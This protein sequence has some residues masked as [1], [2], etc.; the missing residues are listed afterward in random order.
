MELEG[1]VNSIVITEAEDRWVWRPNMDD[2]F[3]VKSLYV[4]LD[5]LLS[6]CIPITLFEAFAYRSMW[7]TA[8]PSKV[9]AFAWQLFLNRTPRKDNLTRR[10]ITHHGDA[11][12]VGCNR[13]EESAIHLFLHCD[14]A[15][16]V[17][18]TVCRW[19]DVVIVLP[20][21][22]MMSYGLMVGSGRN[23]RVRKGFSIVWSRDVNG[24][25]WTRIV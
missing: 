1:L 24:Y 8:L 25:S 18:Y 3:S 19:L 7:K 5:V 15:A 23:K 12:C 4:T 22:I 21:D 16:T 11:I 10:G 13:L 17:W 14:L 9:G 6:P 20:P 2:G